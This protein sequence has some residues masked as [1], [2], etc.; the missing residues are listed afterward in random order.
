M[1]EKSKIENVKGG[2]AFSRKIS[3]KAARKLKAR[4]NSTQGVWFGLGMMGLIGWSVAIP[5]LLGA[6][7]GIWLDKHHSASYSWTLTLL[8]IGLVIG[9]VNVWHWVSKEDKEMR[10]EQEDNDE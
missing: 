4:R 5:T 9:C 1:S 10:D 7:L 3:A 6:A 8:V 2:T